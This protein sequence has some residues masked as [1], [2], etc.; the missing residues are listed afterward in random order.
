MDIENLESMEKI[1]ME[2]KREFIF[3]GVSL[4]WS[5]RTL[6]MEE[7][8]H[9]SG[10][11]GV[12]KKYISNFLKFFLY[13][14]DRELLETKK[15]I[16]IMLI[17]GIP[18]VIKDKGKYRDN[19][20]NEI[21]KYIKSNGFTFE[22]MYPP[23]PPNKAIEFLKIRKRMNNIELLPVNPYEFKEFN[24]RHLNLLPSSSRIINQTYSEV[25]SAYKNY[26]EIIKNK[27]PK[28]LI[29]YNEKGALRYPAIV[30]AKKMGI[31]VVAIQHGI[32][33][34][35]HPSYYHDPN[36]ISKNGD[37]ID[38]LLPDITC[39]YGEYEYRLLQDYGSYPEKKLK[40]TGSPRY[41]HL[42][43]LLSI[44]K[45]KLIKKYSLSSEKRYLLWATQTHDKLMSKTGENKINAE[46]VF[47]EMKKI[48][49]WNLII[50]LH[51]GEDQKAKLYKRMMK[52]YDIDVNIFGRNADTGELI[53]LSDAVLIKNSTVGMEAIF[54]GKPV[55]LLNIVKSHSLET[56][57]KY[58]FDLLINKKED[59]NRLLYSIDDDRFRI[60]FEKKR[61]YFMRERCANPGKSAES[62]WKVIESLMKNG[63]L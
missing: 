27:K 55:L 4:W 60:E 41:D 53:R 36:N 20:L 58:G 59:L 15:E 40:I 38:Y 48:D 9:P 49:D 50:K 47:S 28:I 37:F 33:Y 19:V 34:Q 25:K 10:L 7:K 30:A 1:G 13:A 17:G 16:D 56:Y 12:F 14:I 5:I 44:P 29:L 52:K 61:K 11:G 23:V 18:A 21:I 2:K 3:D 43:E 35:G 31:P 54:L 46:A 32:I 6:Y 45:E 57:T 8:M 26:L 24:S 42:F 51:P 63:N 22:I 62:V 39:V